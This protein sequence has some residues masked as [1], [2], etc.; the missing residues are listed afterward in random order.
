ML[1][2]ILRVAYL[3]ICAGAILA[4]ITSDNEKAEST[5]IPFIVNGETVMLPRASPEKDLL[6]SIIANNKAGAFFVLLLISQSVTILDLMI[7]HRHVS[8]ERPV[9]LAR[10]CTVCVLP[11]ST[12]EECG[13]C[14]QRH[15]LACLAL[16][17]NSRSLA[18]VQ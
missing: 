8:A 11:R 18:R 13:A 6:P 7:R 14:G 3:L 17:G 4:Y 1:L 2:M 5:Q 9:N 16:Y 12:G 15:F 10:R